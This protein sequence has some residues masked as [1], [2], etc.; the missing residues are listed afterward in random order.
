MW[1]SAS[2]GRGEW[3]GVRTKVRLRF[4][5]LAV[6]VFGMVGVHGGVAQTTSIPGP[7]TPERP[8]LTVEEIAV[9]DA[10]VAAENAARLPSFARS[11]A[12]ARIG[13]PLASVQVLGTANVFGA[14]IASPPGGGSLPPMVPVQAGKTYSLDAL[15]L[16]DCCGRTPQ[17]GPDGVPGYSRV[18]PAGGLSRIES[19][20]AMMLTGVFLGPIAAVAP[21]PGQLPIT[22]GNF[23]T[24]SPAIGQIFFIGDGRSVSDGIQQFV[25]PSTATRLFLGIADAYGFVGNPDAYHDNPGSFNASIFLTVPPIYV[26]FGDSYSSGEGAG[27]YIPPTDQRAPQEDLCHRSPFAYSQVVAPRSPSGT[28]LF[29]LASRAFFACSGAVTK[30]VRNLKRQYVPENTGDTDGQIAH[31]EVPAASLITMTIGGND[32]GFSDIIKHCLWRDN[33]VGSAFRI[34]GTQI[35][36]S[37][38]KGTLRKIKGKVAND[39]RATYAEINQANPSAIKIAMNYP[40]LFPGY[41]TGDNCHKVGNFGGDA[42]NTYIDAEQQFF[43]EATLEIS[44]VIATESTNAGWRFVDVI[45]HFAGHEICGTTGNDWLYGFKGSAGFSI[46]PESGSFHPNSQGQAEYAHELQPMIE[47]AVTSSAATTASARIANPTLGSVDIDSTLLALD[48]NERDLVWGSP[49]EITPLIVGSSTCAAVFEANQ[50][51]VVSGRGYQPGT[52]IGLSYDS[53]ASPENSLGVVTA[54]ATGSFTATVT[55]PPNVTQQFGQGLDAVGFDT[56]GNV[57][58]SSLDLVVENPGGVCATTTPLPA[59]FTLKADVELSPGSIAPINNQKGQL[60]AEVQIEDDLRLSG[61]ISYKIVPNGL[62]FENRTISARRLGALII[63][64]GTGSLGDH[65]PVGYSAVFNPAPNGTPGDG[66]RLK[67]ISTDG[68]VL[69]DQAIGSPISSAPPIVSGG[70]I[71]IRQR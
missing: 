9:L 5:V 52:A 35:F 66:A 11:S 40:H 69:I 51:V 20:R 21:A 50:D 60:K 67:L 34:P 59:K 45:P 29:P 48:P 55:L 13:R 38:R 2:G 39:L 46:M 17:I 3:G 43:R 26:A 61:S 8:S 57:L 14:G 56:D 54:D 68:T 32:A 58:V 65:I 33:C 62:E 4:V 15:G 42:N 7:V 25:A 1:T 12:A 22:D 71:T 44:K 53:S 63:I 37:I 10:R 6:A 30:N 70:R 19:S 23:A 16:I 28:L 31:P 36:G 47:Q 41:P 18:G 49:L 24:L 27:S 64:T